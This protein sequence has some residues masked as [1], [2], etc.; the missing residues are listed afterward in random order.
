ME[1]AAFDV[2]I[3]VHTIEIVAVADLRPHPRNYRTHPIDQ[4][5][6]LVASLD[7]HGM[8]RS[9]VF[10]RHAAAPDAHAGDNN[11]YPA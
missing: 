2:T 5:E 11:P 10:V 1:N 3:P 4:V 6:H 9:V 7:K 8:Y